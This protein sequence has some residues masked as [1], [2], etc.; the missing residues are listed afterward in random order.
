MQFYYFHFKERTVRR[1]SG[2][3]VKS[4]PVEYPGLERFKVPDSEKGSTWHVLEQSP[5]TYHWAT[6]GHP[7]PDFH[8]MKNYMVKIGHG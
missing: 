1:C 6:G 4:F 7:S 2:S 5:R 3:E 8:D